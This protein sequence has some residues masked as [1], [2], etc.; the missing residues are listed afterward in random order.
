ML[1][2]GR[3]Q[4][5]KAHRGPGGKLSKLLSRDDRMSLKKQAR[6]RNAS[7]VVEQ[8]A[9]AGGTNRAPH[10]VTVLSLDYEL[11]ASEL[12]GRLIGADEAA[13]V[14]RAQRSGVVYMNV[15]RYKTRYGFLCPSPQSLESL[16]DCLRVS[17]ALLVLWPTDVE[18]IDAHRALL[19]LLLAHGVPE[20]MHVTVGLPPPGKQR[21]Q[22]RKTIQRAIEKWFVHLKVIFG[23][24]F[25][26]GIAPKRPTSTQRIQTAIKCKS[27]ANFLPYERNAK[28]KN[29]SDRKSSSMRSWRKM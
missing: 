25:L 16:F 21:E 5:T 2:E 14:S 7:I 12:V 8:R 10:L 24:F 29:L 19:D 11:L 1:V 17:D 18:E 27:C 6:Q 28:S 26:V 23:N 22:A 15:P 13:I 4:I 9:A 20:I 3:K